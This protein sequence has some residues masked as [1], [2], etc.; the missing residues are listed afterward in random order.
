V[1]LVREHRPGPRFQVKRIL[2]KPGAASAC[3]C[4][5]TAPSTGSSSRAPPR[6]PTATR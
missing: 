5:T 2:V 1:G 3:R 6:S 4:I